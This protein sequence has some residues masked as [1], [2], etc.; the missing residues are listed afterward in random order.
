MPT[1][2]QATPWQ[3][4]SLKPELMGTAADPAIESVPPLAPLLTLPGWLHA[5]SCSTAAT[6]GGSRVNKEHCE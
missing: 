6:T 4:R 5:L 2:C 1:V 3:R